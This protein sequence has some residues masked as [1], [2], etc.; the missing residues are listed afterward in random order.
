MNWKFAK[1]FPSSIQNLII[2]FNKLPG[3]GNKTSQ[4]FVFY[5]LKQPKSEIVKLGNA[6]EHLKDEIKY[7]D[8]CHC[9]TEKNP[10]PICADSGR[11]KSV[12]SVVSE[13]SEMA[14]FENMGEYKGLY[15]I[16]GGTINTLD[17]ITPD[18]LNVR[19][20]A[21]RVKNG[22]FSEIILAFNSDIEGETT[23]MYLK[24]IL[25]PFKIKITRLARGLP[26]GS[27]IEYADEI[28]LSNA[29]KGRNAA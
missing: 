2:E 13:T 12:L 10:C 14:V 17:G 20:L 26:M 7:C 1:V 19:S 4:R 22:N 16:L 21:D 18:M 29:F 9:F 25:E 11:D 5:L 27:D 28:T 6:L 24:K 8:I 3:I 23:V 15:H